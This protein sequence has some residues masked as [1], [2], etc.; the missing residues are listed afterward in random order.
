ML[1]A[2]GGGVTWGSIALKWGDRTE[3]VGIHV[4][5]LPDTDMTVFDLLREN[6]DFYAPLH[7]DEP[8]RS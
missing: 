3:P 6:L 2:F 1:T 8:P 4:G 5:E 7:V